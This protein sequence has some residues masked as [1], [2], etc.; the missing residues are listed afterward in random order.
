MKLSMVKL[1][2]LATTIFFN[3]LVVAAAAVPQIGG[4]VANTN[5]VLLPSKSVVKPGETFSVAVRV[6]PAAGTDVA[7]MQFDLSWDPA[8]LSVNSV[9][10]GQF[11]D[12]APIFFQPGTLNQNAGTLK[13]VVNV[14]TSVGGQT[15]PGTMINITCTALAAGKTSKFVLSN[16]VAGNSDGNAIPLSITVSQVVCAASWDVNLDGSVDSADMVMVAAALGTTG[17]AGWRRED[18]NG[19]GVINILDLILVGQAFS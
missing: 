9:Q 8:A 6:E 15:A 2:L 3:L 14:V 12:P 16:A 17:P 7:G 19:D 1:V 11:F 13:A 5:V 10:P 4:S 18:V